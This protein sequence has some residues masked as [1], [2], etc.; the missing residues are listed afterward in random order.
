MKDIFMNIY[1]PSFFDWVIQTSIMASILVGLI[2]CVKVL[3]RSKLTPRWHYLLW[4][5]LIVRLIFPWSPFNSY[6]IYSFLENGDN[7]T[8]SVQ[9]QPVIPSQNNR[10]HE[11]SSPSTR[12]IKEGNLNEVSTLQTSSDSKEVNV[13]HLDKEQ[14]ESISLYNIAY[15]IWLTGVIIST[16]ITYALN[17]NLHR[18]IQKQPVISDQRIIRFLEDCKKVMSVKQNIP[19][20]LSGEI[21]SPTVLGFIRPKIL[22]SSEYM[23]QLNDEQLRHIF[24]HELAHIKRR[25]VCINWIMHFLLIL[26]W[27]NP[28][29]WWAYFCM[30]EDQELACDAYALTFMGED[31]KIS[32]G[33]TIISLLERYS[34]HYQGPSLANLSRNKRTIKRRIILIKKF[35]KK[36]Y[37]WSAL[38]V[39]AIIVVSTFSLINTHAEVSNEEQKEQ[40]K[41]KITTHEKTNKE[42][43][44]SIYTPPVQKES[45]KDMKKE[46]VLTKLLN[47]IDNFHTAIGKFESFYVYDNSTR[48]LKVEYKISNKNVIGGYEKYISISDDKITGSSIATNEMFYDEK[49]NWSI[50]SDKQTYFKTSYVPEPSRRIIKPEDAFSINLNKIYDSDDKFREEPPRGAY[51]ESLFPYEKTA[52][53]LRYPNLWNIEKQNEKVLGHNTIVLSGS[54]DSSIVDITQPH[55]NSFRFWVDKDTG[56]LIKYEIYNASGEIISYLHPEKLLVNAPIDRTQFI[57]SLENHD[58]ITMQEPLYKDPR[59][60]EIEIIEHADT[61]PSSVQK[62]MEIQRE[63]IPYFYEFNDTIVTPFSASIEEHKGQQQAYVVYSYDK[64]DTERGS[65]SRL[66]YTRIYPRV[67]VVRTT[68]DFNSELGEEK[69]NFTLEEIKWSVFE[70][71]G[72]PNIQLKGE[73]DEFVYEIVTQ[74]VSLQE[75]K[76]LL[77]TFIR[78]S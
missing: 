4:M 2:L 71:K 28:I 35:E 14:E 26:N 42:E 74:E 54:I 23:H 20:L 62:V 12:E 38:G 48:K 8:V 51:S 18:Y 33:N 15:F 50:D 45:Y 58:D 6:S 25:D 24:Y 57:P 67:C 60:K 5:I 10:N 61:I 13:V 32:Y 64:P 3:L 27:F 31:E 46:E 66:L 7:D 34:N 43:K 78:S 63:T 65:G 9:S 22:L 75:V 73:K 36:S 30:R 17:R 55:A 47:T 59:E 76:E 72:T 40:V 44:D 77:A 70:I 49:T 52:V 16:F 21:A 41:N 29:L 53:Y 69:E 11:L 1:L 19:L 39:I 37:R 56:I 68:G